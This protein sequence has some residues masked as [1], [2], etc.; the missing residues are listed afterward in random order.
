MGRA[1]DNAML[2]VNMKDVAKGN[3]SWTK[4]LTITVANS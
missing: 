3:L 1:L 2:N 4:K